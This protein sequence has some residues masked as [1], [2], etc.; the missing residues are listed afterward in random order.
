MK[1]PN[2]VSR[3]KFLKTSLGTAAAVGFPTIVPSSI[4]GE[5]PPSRRINVGAIGVGRISRA[6]DLPGIWPFDG[7]RIMAVCDLDT[8]RVESGKALI[9]DIYAKKSSK[10]YNGVTGYHDYHDLLANKDIDAV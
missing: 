6:H 9:N 10:P 5:M 8:N 3:R 7:A 1:N 2:R 4:F